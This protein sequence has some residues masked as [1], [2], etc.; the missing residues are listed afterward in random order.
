MW[1]HYYLFNIAAMIESANA[2]SSWSCLCSSVLAAAMCARLTAAL[3]SRSAIS[4][5][6]M[7]TCAGTY[8]TRRRMFAAFK[9]VSARRMTRHR[10]AFSRGCP[11]RVH[12]SASHRSIQLFMPSTQSRLSLWTTRQ[13]NS[14]GHA[15]AFRT[16]KIMAVSSAL[17]FV[18]LPG[19]RSCTRRLT[20]W[21]RW[22]TIGWLAGIGGKRNSNSTMAFRKAMLVM[23]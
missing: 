22:S 10:S 18:C 14:D 21:N 7:P 23:K 13:L 1:E 9:A 3:A 12:P 16:A 8:L 19:H 15:I 17:L 5:P 2:S 4:F 20:F 11:I 6:Y